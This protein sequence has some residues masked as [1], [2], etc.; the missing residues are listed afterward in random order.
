MDGN[1]F[2]FLARFYGEFTPV[3]SSDGKKIFNGLASSLLNTA[4]PALHNQA[5]ME[6]GALHCKPVNPS[7]DS[8]PFQS[9]CIANRSGQVSLLPVKSKTSNI[10]TRYFNYLL[11]HYNE[12]IFLNKRTSGDIWA[13]LYEL[14]LIETLKRV[15]TENLMRTKQWQQYFSGKFDI[16]SDK[17]FAVHKL[18]HQHIYAR[19][20]E[21]NLSAKPK[22]LFVNSFISVKPDE[23]HKYPVSR[24]VENMLNNSFKEL[25]EAAEP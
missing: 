7:C 6:F 12:K 13:Q 18:S 5:I 10:K 3:N 16:K 19:V 1:V 4:K 24:L 25:F 11:V 20:L 9:S 15:S 22:K 2:R 17:Q 21:I 23:I 8:C 14:P